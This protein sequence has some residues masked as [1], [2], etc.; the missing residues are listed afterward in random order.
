MATPKVHRGLMLTGLV[1]AVLA[2]SI[3]IGGPASASASYDIPWIGN[4]ATSSVSYVIP[5]Q[6]SESPGIRIFK[7]GTSIY[8]KAYSSYL[9]CGANPH[10]LT[11]AAI[12]L[13]LYRSYNGYEWLST[14]GASNTSTGTLAPTANFKAE[15]RWFGHCKGYLKVVVHYGVQ[16]DAAVGTNWSNES[17]WL[18]C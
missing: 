2:G 15:T 11:Y 12:D 9:Y 10:G 13:H 17:K 8:H 4:P 18:R 1:A 16:G 14:L 6:L 3:L 7:S 5:C